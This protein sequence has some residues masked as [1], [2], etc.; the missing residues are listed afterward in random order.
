MMGSGGRPARPAWAAVTIAV[1][2]A[3]ALIGCTNRAPAVRTSPSAATALY[4]RPTWLL[5]RPALAL[6][7]ADP[8][9]R[10]GLGRSQV[11]EI[12]QPGQLPVPGVDATLVAAFTAVAALGD[13]LTGNRLSAGTGAVLYDP[14]AWSFTP[15]AEQ[16]DPVQ[17]AAQAAALAHAYGLKIIVAPA[18]NLT[19]VLTPGS[20]APKWRQ[21]LDLQLAAKIA[22]VADFLDLQAQSLER[23]TASYANFVRTAAAQARAANPQVT[24][25]AGLSTNPPGAVLDSPQL[26]AAIQASWSAVDGYWLNI[27][28]PGPRCPT[29]N[30][31]RP[32]IGI[33]ALQAI[34]GTSDPR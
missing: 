32:D 7:A 31:I 4:G 27:P 33:E 9:V 21:F 12:V 14:E 26:I 8:A 3:W 30:P 6:L 23:N 18:L 22:A 1:A 34:L 2:M 20:S 10:A 29:C 28:S 5:T 17:A 13:A 25:L 15:A 11:Y 24:V 19:T 16:R